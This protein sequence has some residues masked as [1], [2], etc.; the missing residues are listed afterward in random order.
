M[1][2]GRV[3]DAARVPGAATGLERRDRTG[4]LAL[5]LPVS[6]EASVYP[7]RGE[8]GLELGRLPSRF[9]ECV[10]LR[11]ASAGGIWLGEISGDARGEGILD[12]GFPSDERVDFEMER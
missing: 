6:F 5:D 2:I 12:P 9:E 10:A 7:E 4:D 11:E 8:A 3:E 1:G